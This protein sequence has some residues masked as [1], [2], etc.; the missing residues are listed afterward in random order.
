MG[1]FAKRARALVILTGLVPFTAAQAQ[2]PPACKFELKISKIA[3]AEGGLFTQD[4]DPTIQGRFQLKVEANKVKP[5]KK[6][7]LVSPTAM[8]STAYLWSIDGTLS[9][10]DLEV[11][12][13]FTV[14]QGEEGPTFDAVLNIEGSAENYTMETYS[15][16]NWDTLVDSNA[17]DKFGS[18][19]KDVTLA[20]DSSEFTAEN[21]SYVFT[22]PKGDIGKAYKAAQP[23]MSALLKKAY[24][25]QCQ[26]SHQVTSSGSSSGG[27]F[28]T[29]ATCEAVGLADDCWELRTLRRFRDGWLAEQQGGTDDIAAYYAKAPAIAERLKREP[30]ALLRLYWTRIVPSALAAQFGAN[31]VARAIYS[32][33][34]RELAEG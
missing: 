25:G 27:C 13:P 29:T 8:V 28:L 12:N 34:M 1:S 2:T 6:E 26:P 18:L 17:A 10:Y 24:A 19:K 22:F 32:K 9:S 21:M 23:Q 15:F 33:G 7:L 30:Q 5:N 3:T 20:L 14:A 16:S 4:A 31:R 11:R